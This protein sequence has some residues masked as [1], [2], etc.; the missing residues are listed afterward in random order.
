VAWNNA[1]FTERIAVQVT[2]KYKPVLPN[3][4]FMGNEFDIR[5][6]AVMGSE[7]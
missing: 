7:G 6:V 3:F 2:G 5:I 4:L 1:Q